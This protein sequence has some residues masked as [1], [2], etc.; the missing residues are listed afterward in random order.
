MMKCKKGIFLAFLL[1]FFST[2]SNAGEE[3]FV[4]EDI[5]IKGLQRIEPGTIFTYLPIEI[6]DSFNTADAPKII[7]TL[8]KT[9]FFN[10]V[11]I[12]R[13]GNVVVITVD[14][15][16]TIVDIQF[17]GLEDITEDAMQD[18]LIA[19][20]IQPGRIYNDSILDRIESEL[21]EQYHAPINQQIFK[22]Q[23]SF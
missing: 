7:K 15:R 12:E 8:F 5:V 16:P 17:L 1:L 3:L 19:A 22:K 13:E 14:E 6:G 18:V 23:A 20:G 21:V 9:K 10:D 4:I 11:V 2:H